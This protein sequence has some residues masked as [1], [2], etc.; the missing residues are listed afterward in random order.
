[1]TI[2]RLTWINWVELLFGVLLPGVTLGP[3]F[4]LAAVIGPL[5]LATSERAREAAPVSIALIL[6]AL[7]GLLSL[8][9]L[10]AVILVGPAAIHRKPTWRF[11]ALLLGSVG[12]AVGGWAVK[13][14]LSF[15]QAA[16]I[17]FVLFGAPV[18]VGTRYFL[19]L[20]FGRSS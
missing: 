14:S 5:T 1:M 4:A 7:F 12:L 20:I 6:C 9:C 11:G 3:F 15:G 10:G 13:A 8:A 2:R 18:V 17:G 19:A 16:P